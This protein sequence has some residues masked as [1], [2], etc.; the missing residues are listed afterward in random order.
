MSG[1][2][3]RL[4]VCAYARLPA[5]FYAPQAPTL[6][7][8]PYLIAFN[9][10]LG[11]QLGLSGG[12]GPR[13][14]NTLC[15]NHVPAHVQPLAAAYAG[16]Q[17]GVYVPQ[18][19]DG[20][21]L[22]L[23]DLIDVDGARHELQLK[24]AGP[25]PFSRGAD[26]RAVLRSTIREYLASEAMHGL[27]IPTTRAL[28][29]VGSDQPVY[30]E[31]IETAAVLA[32]LA[33]SHVRFGSFEFFHYRGEAQRVA[34]LADFVIDTQFP[35]L[36]G[37][38]DRHDHLLREVIE[39]TARLVAAWQA[40]GFVHGVMN[41]DNMSI[42]GL[43]LD[44]GPYGFLDHFEAARVFNHT[45]QRGR[46]AYANQGRVGLWNLHALAEALST[47]IPADAREAALATFEPLF[48]GAYGELMRRKLGL[49]EARA[50]DANLVDRLLQALQ[51][52][53]VDYPAF[54]RGLGAFRPDDAATRAPL[55]ALSRAPAALA[56]WLDDYAGRLAGE[57]DPGEARQA[58]MD[59]INPLYV[60]RTHLAERAIRRAADHRDYSE[61][62]RLRRLLARPFTPCPEMDEYAAPPPDDGG[63]IELSCSS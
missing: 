31:Q 45:D 37:L 38:P 62:E 11:G 56:A 13:D 14:I 48:V 36:G 3:Q 21:A 44:Y 8:Q 59:A 15:G 29:I 58:R 6:L 33:P 27:G 40:Q 43:T 5:D 35:A 10:D 25:T 16:H 22:L 55:L 20:R 1:I 7:P 61:I 52:G 12:L 53:R 51:A 47:L 50:Q 4:L 26:G 60:L 57:S 39:R 18:L 23:G 17:F 24:G 34:Q 46:Y 2:E 42:L 63:A 19:G 32:R 30:R 54:M 49:R 28:A 9:L 41:T